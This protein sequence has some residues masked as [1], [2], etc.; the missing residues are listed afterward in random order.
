M[1]GLIRRLAIAALA[2]A[3]MSAPA[4]AQEDWQEWNAADELGWV[5][6]AADAPVTVIEY[7]S[8]TCSHCKEFAED[9][10]PVVEEKYVATGKIRLVMREWV[11]NSVD[12]TILT[13]ARC[14][15]K[16]DGL[17]Y[18]KDI[19]ARQ[20]EIFVAA[21]VG[22]LPGTLLIVGTPY[23]ISDREK[24]DTCYQNMDIR[25]DMLEVDKSSEHYDVHASPTFIVDGT[26]YAATNAMMTPEGFTAFLD[27]E[28]AKS[29]PA[30]N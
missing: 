17:S 18:L 26:P 21:Q 7:F 10:L 12:K 6:G 27:A 13:Q 5:E 24:F 25:F 3:A 8:P 4:R 16:E 1:T 9:V 22:T 30:T 2:C 15:P 29:T 28:L 11:R 19:F 20:D 23:G 14:L